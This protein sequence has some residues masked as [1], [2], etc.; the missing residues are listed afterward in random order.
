MPVRVATPAAKLMMMLGSF[1]EPSEFSITCPALLKTRT[2]VMAIDVSPTYPLMKFTPGSAAVLDALILTTALLPLC[3]CTTSKL[4]DFA[5]KTP[6]KSTLDSRSASFWSRLGMVTFCLAPVTN[7][8][9]MPS[10][11]TII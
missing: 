2:L 7:E 5:L 3:S 4:A 11:S 6:V 8:K 9:R 1:A 10:C